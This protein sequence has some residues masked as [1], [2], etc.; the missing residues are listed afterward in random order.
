MRI[1][2]GLADAPG[3]VVTTMKTVAHRMNV[4][5]G[6][7]EKAC[8]ARDTAQAKI[9]QL[10]QRAQEGKDT[11]QAKTDAVVSGAKGLTTQARA[12]I[13]EPLARRIEPLTQAT[14]QRP[15]LLAAAA[16]VVGVLP[17]LRYLRRRNKR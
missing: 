1:G 6:V 8:I 2:D 17:L 10:M 15:I 4:P 14:R 7:K 11:A 16:L 9:G 12:Q 3:R 5:S 13:P